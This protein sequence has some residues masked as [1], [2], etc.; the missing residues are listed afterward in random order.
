ML[1][2]P[3]PS[4]QKDAPIVTSFIG[5]MGGRDISPE[6]FFEM[7]AVTS[8]AAPIGQAAPPRLLYSEAELGKS[9]NF[10][11]SHMWTGRSWELIKS[12]GLLGQGIDVSLMR[13]FA[14]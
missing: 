8:Q 12:R 9:V 3:R 10:R 7:A 1:N 13:S 4:I 5:G 11:R 2:W 14:S 6:E